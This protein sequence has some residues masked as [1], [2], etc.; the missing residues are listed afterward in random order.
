MWRQ[1]LKTMI[2]KFEQT[3]YLGVKRGRRRKRISNKTVEQVAF[4]VVKGE[5][6]SQYSA[7]SARDASHDL[8]VLWSTA[9]KILRSILKLYPYKIS[10]VQHLNPVDPGKSLNFAIILLVR[11]IVD[12]EWTWNILWS[13]EAHFTLNGEVN[14][15]NC[16]IWGS[17]LP[18]IVDERSLHSNYITA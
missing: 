13:V 11:I 9:R 4:A 7:S 6:C 10:F 2:Q 1:A 12:T 3:G 5:F 16:R 15:N 17:A 14:R 8:F 18:C